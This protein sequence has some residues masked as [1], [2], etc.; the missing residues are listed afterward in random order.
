M[1]WW[2][3]WPNASANSFQVRLRPTRPGKFQ[4]Y[5]RITA[6]DDFDPDVWGYDP[7][8]ELPGVVRDQ[9]D[10]AVYVHV[11]EVQAES[12]AVQDDGS[13]QGSPK[14]FFISY[15]KADRAWAEWIA[16]QLEKEGYMAVIQAWDF[17][18]GSNFVL[19]MDKTATEAERTVAVLSPNY[20]NSLYTQPEWSDAF[21][22][23][24][25]GEKGLLL[26]VL[27]QECEVPGLL[28]S[29]VYIDL[30]GQSEAAACDRLLNGVRR[31][32]SKP[33][34]PPKFPS[35]VPEES[36]FPGI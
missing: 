23:D 12:V 30:V 27:V 9:Q 26:P 17:Q 24:P 6:Q 34:S 22:R 36:H 5:A 10:E 33:T 14:H 7:H 20:L 18:P 15:N 3:K 11:V 31:E 4:I 2:E 28:G 19:E 8:P 13:L 1:G 16:W 35:S 29:T 32:R 21:R 25:K